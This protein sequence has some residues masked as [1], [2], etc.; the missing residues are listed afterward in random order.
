MTDISKKRTAPSS[1][2][3]NDNEAL[4][5]CLPYVD[6]MDDKYE[7]Y[8]LSLIEEEMKH[9]QSPRRRREELQQPLPPVTFRTP[10]MKE[11]YL[12]IMKAAAAAAQNE[13][14]KEDGENETTTHRSVV[15]RNSNFHY[16]VVV[17]PPKD[18]EEDVQVWMDAVRDARIDYELERCRSITLEAKKDPGMAWLWKQWIGLL[19]RDNVAMQA[20]LDRER[21]I[22]DAINLERSEAQQA[23]R[24]RLQRLTN[25]Y[26]AALERRFRLQQAI[27]T[28]EQELKQQQQQQ[29]QQQ[30]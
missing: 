10:I 16:R 13:P 25:K 19:D 20:R 29:Q 18:D 6:V 27:V 21:Q 14:E 2:G 7:Q 1:N 23:A 11:E 5:D 3:N 26:Q 9:V 22:V 17:D 15:P 28:L 24:T 8:A 4:I 12:Y 30:E